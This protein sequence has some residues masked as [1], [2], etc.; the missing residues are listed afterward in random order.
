M[1]KEG[2][3]RDIRRQGQQ[4]PKALILTDGLGGK[5]SGS[6][7]TIL[8]TDKRRCRPSDFTH[9]RWT[10]KDCQWTGS[11]LPKHQTGKIKLSSFVVVGYEPTSCDCGGGKCQFNVSTTVS[12]ARGPGTARTSST[13]YATSAKHRVRQAWT[14]R[15]AAR[16][17]RVRK[18]RRSGADWQRRSGGMAVTSFLQVRV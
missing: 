14:S 13:R 6:P 12:A 11:G 17:R 2:G 5:L 10:Y 18:L 8:V 15:I 4:R 9:G 1:R 7:A 3:E 16:R